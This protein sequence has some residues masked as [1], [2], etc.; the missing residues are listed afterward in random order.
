MPS[1]PDRLKAGLR[2]R[3]R[4]PG[5]PPVRSSAFT[6]S[7]ES[8]CP[9][10]GSLRVCC[11]QRRL[12]QTLL[13]ALCVLTI[14][15]SPAAEGAASVRP[16]WT[17]L[18]LGKAVQFSVPPNYPAVTDVEDARQMTDGTL[19]TAT[20][21]WSDRAAVGWV[22]VEPVVFTV[23]LGSDQP[24]RG[25]AVHVPG[26]LGGVEWPGSILLYASATGAR[27]SLVGDLV[28][29]SRVR[30]PETGYATLWLTTEALETHGRFLKFVCAPTNL[31]NGAY[32]FV[33]EVEVY[34]GEADWLNRAL[35][36]ANAPA[37]WRAVWP[38]I[39]WREQTASTPAAERPTHLRR[40][41]GSTEAGADTPLQQAVVEGGRVR[42][43]LNGEAG[44]VRALTW[45]AK[46]A[47]PIST[48]R[49]RYALLSFRAEGMRR[50]FEPRPLVTLQGVNDAS[51]E[52]SVSLLEANMALNDGLLH[53]LIRPLP[54][55]FTL[56]QLKVWIS[57]ENDAPSLVLER[58]ELLDALPDVFSAEIAPAG[59]PVPEGLVPVPLGAVLN[60]TLAEWYERALAA[61][62]TLLDGARA[63]P[64]GPVTVS[65]VPFVIAPAER[66][67]A[68][69]P[70]S[71]ETNETVDFLGEKVERRYLGPISR[72]DALSVDLDASAREVFLLL[73]L[74]APAVQT[75][76]GLPNCALRL[77]DI[78][79]IAVELTY[80]QGENEI[81]FPYSLA[82]HG[83]YVPARELGAYAVA[84]DPARRLRRITLHNHHF[85][86]SFA[87]AGL[88]LNPTATA[89]VP[90][91]ARLPAPEPTTLHPDPAPAPVSIAQAGTRLTLRNRW[92]EVGFDLAQGFAIDR[93]VNRIN[94]ASPIRLAPSSGLRLRLGDTVYSGRSFTAEV[95][96]LGA[97]DVELRLSSLRPEL[98]LEITVTMTAD[99]SPE[100]AF[101]ALVR[102]RGGTPLAAELCLPALAGLA[103]GDL[104]STRLFFPQY[105]AVDTAAP[106]ALRAP[107]G[108]EF[109]GQFMDVYS[110]PEGIGLMLR[111]NNP[112]H[113]MATFALRKDASGVS[114]GISS[115]AEYNELA[116]G[117]SLACLPV[118]LLVH[119]GDWH[120]AFELYRAWLR[121]WY[122]PYKAQD[123]DYFL[124]AW[125]MTVY[126]P[127]TRIAWSE[128]LTPALITP[129]RKRFLLDETFAFEKQ[130]L[131]HV[132]DLVHLF[133]WTYTDQKQRNEYGVYGA[134]LAYAQVGGL[135]VFRQG[136]AAIQTTW[137]RPVSLYTLSDRF[138]ASALPDQA[139]SQE[140]VATSAYQE[141][142]RDA[143]AAVRGAGA[144]DGIFYP[145]PGN[146]KWTDYVVNDIVTMQRDTGCR[147]VY[148]DVFPYFSHLRGENGIS[149]LAADLDV[150]VKVREAL[151]ADVALW[152]EY[153]LPDVASRYADGA[154]QYYF[155][156]LNEVF[157]RR[158]NRSDRA[159]E[160]FTELPFNLARYALPRYRTFALPCYIEGGSK[161]SQVDA[162]FVN[163]E[164]FH[165]DTWRLHHSRLREKLN[166]A[167]VVKHEY[168]DCF[169]GTDPLPQVETAVR[170]IA[171]NLFT[172][173][174]RKLWTLYNGLPRT[175]AGVVLAVPH[176][177]GARYRDAWNGGDLTPAISAGLAQIVVTLHPQQPG[178][179]VQEWAP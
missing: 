3:R 50:T 90:E 162:V 43:T 71:K 131:G 159:D 19:A 47:K 67:L 59:A 80:D 42:F 28:E 133:N 170:G 120:A 44:R 148:M 160:L 29:L 36:A 54:E 105:R 158:Y 26:G 113:I 30:P 79:S 109:T 20:P 65:G 87:L 40:V 91:L 112:G 126:R 1:S 149:P 34:Q 111:S 16:P 86:P 103:L 107:Y 132:P 169:N 64:A 75:R 68:L 5:V 72:D 147:M 73:A 165:E 58:L 88:T 56:Q 106:I 89:V 32:I 134:P 14:P 110:R 99:D 24:I 117:A 154:V 143:S 119:G 155:L 11:A 95:T 10:L 146:R 78:E 60:G 74:S 140:L 101:A 168:S 76:G 23:G 104:A 46:L 55:G 13:L 35:V 85:G 164:P 156:D 52:N 150:V 77:D 127:S 121:S 171:A 167:Y 21:M 33:D 93:L 138:R 61:H 83:C 163:G 98:P 38:E 53:T 176:Q 175:Y 48:E 57:S 128:N 139:L 69:M 7:G 45:T 173:K 8:G 92:Y 9:R 153:S 145:R 166:R 123:K 115:P 17:N 122:T 177:D 157:A 116:P 130:Y 151:P 137:Q 97:T 18:A 6:R 129:D 144:V 141:L 172:G 124:N 25:V 96:R 12:L 108:P 135:E 4:S 84:L 31:G 70:E 142:D 37:Q 62:T 94:P 41:D 179:V 178:C 22:M 27:Y 82:D 125:D 63:L 114:G 39:P 15:A 152:T 100:L 118:S 66:N 49:C 102:N 51:A 81:A 136:I 2:T 174:N 161:P